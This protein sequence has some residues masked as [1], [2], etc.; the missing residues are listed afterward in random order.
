MGPYFWYHE[1]V[2]HI[3]VYFNRN[4]LAFAAAYVFSSDIADQL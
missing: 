3:T 4:K 1:F 2:P